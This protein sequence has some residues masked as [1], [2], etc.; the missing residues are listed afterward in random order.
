MDYKQFCIIY[1][2]VKKGIYYPL[3]D[4]VMVYIYDE[5]FLN[6]F[7]NRVNLKIQCTGYPLNFAYNDNLNYKQYMKKYKKVKLITIDSN[8]NDI[9]INYENRYIILTKDDYIKWVINNEILDDLKSFLNC[10]YNLHK[11]LRIFLYNI[12]NKNI[13]NNKKKSS[14]TLL[15]TD[16][17]NYNW[18]FTKI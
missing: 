2:I 11:Q 8:D 6:L 7:H 14:N 17:N 10:D 4:M 18:L 16:G 15:R 3:C 1:N 9:K 5:I 13:C 12:L